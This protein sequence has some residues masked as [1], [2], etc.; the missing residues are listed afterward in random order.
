M[1]MPVGFDF[2][3]R[4]RV[5][6]AAGAIDRAGELA[7][8]IGANALLVTDPGIVAAG[9]VERAR[10]SLDAA[11][12]SVTIFDKVRENPTTREVDECLEVAR[13]VRPDL[14]IGLGGGSSMDTAKGCNFILTNA[15][16]CRITGASAKRPSRCSR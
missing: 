12:V 6:F 4:T 8:A 3:P 14:I 1:T 7:R 13:A 15:A 10:R 16:G 2:Q 11:E 5:I 9:H